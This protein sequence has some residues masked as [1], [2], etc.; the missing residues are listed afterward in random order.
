MGLTRRKIA[1]HLTLRIKPVHSEACDS[2]PQAD[3]CNGDT[4]PR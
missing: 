3:A 1:L 2:R 4:G